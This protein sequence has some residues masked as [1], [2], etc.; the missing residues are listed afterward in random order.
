VK[1]V[2]VFRCPPQEALPFELV[3]H[4]LARQHIDAEEPLH[5]TPGELKTGHLAVFGLDDLDEADHPWL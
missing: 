4:G 5:L 2:G 1:D 3:N